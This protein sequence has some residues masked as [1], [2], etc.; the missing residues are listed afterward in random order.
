MVRGRGRESCKDTGP[1]NH[2]GAIRLQ[3]PMKNPNIF[4]SV[5][6]LFDPFA[7]PPTSLK[8]CGI[9]HAEVF[10]IIAGMAPFMWSLCSAACSPLFDSRALKMR[11]QKDVKTAYLFLTQPI[12]S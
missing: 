7:A 10:R 11:G 12:M 1:R 3:P 5:F 4:K 8:K 9:S 2:K 6:L